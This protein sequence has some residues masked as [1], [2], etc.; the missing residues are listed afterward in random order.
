MKPKVLVV[1]VVGILVGGGFGFGGAYIFYAPK[2]NELTTDLNDLES[3]H[4][5]LV[6]QHE[7][8]SEQYETLS[9]EYGTLSGQYENL[10]TERDNLQNQYSTLSS[11][12]KV[13]QSKHN[14]LSYDYDEVSGY[15]KDISS[16]LQSTRNL[17]DYYCRIPEAF[18]R[19]LI[20]EELEKAPTEDETGLFIKHYKCEYC[21]H[22]E[23]REQ[24][25][26]KI[27]KKA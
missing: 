3:Q 13:L 17:L 23:A 4:Q 14:I 16:E 1:L 24:V 15:L 6:G 20:K 2:I 7:T 18:K 27:A 5:T 26:H 9:Q 19:V 11:E 22:R 8:I 21:N 12:Y 25:L 10:K